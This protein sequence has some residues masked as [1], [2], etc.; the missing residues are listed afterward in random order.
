MIVTDKSKGAICGEENKAD[1]I[2]QASQ[3]MRR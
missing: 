2:W 1:K 3:K